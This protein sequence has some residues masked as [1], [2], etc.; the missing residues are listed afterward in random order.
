M[1][2]IPKLRRE[3]RRVG[4]EGKEKWRQRNVRGTGEEEEV[5]VEEEEGEPE[6]D[7][8][9]QF[10]GTVLPCITHNSGV[11]TT[12]RG[13]HLLGRHSLMTRGEYAFLLRKSDFK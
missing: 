11:S 8:L 7:T 1:A 10:D 6:K 5:V 12:L 4:E 2:W 3:R 13:N 9:S